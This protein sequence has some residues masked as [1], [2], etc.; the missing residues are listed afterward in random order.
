MRMISKNEK[1]VTLMALIITIIVL[2]IIL[3]I[4]LNYGLSEIHTASNKKTESELVIVQ[5]AI[6]QRYALVKSAN[7]LENKYQTG[8]ANRP[9]KFVGEILESSSKI[10]D[11]GFSGIDYMKDYTT[12]DSNITYEECYYKIG[13]DDLKD[14]GIEKGDSGKEENESAKERTYIINYSTGEVFDVANKKYYKTNSDDDEL[15][16]TQPTDIEMANK[17]YDFND[18]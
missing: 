3:G 7:Q 18:N 4:T 16:Y 1:G 13:E 17:T 2:S 8:E 10:A 14:L 12:L 5:E 11:Y 15:I 6:M 9:E